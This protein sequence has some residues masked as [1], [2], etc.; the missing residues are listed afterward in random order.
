MHSEGQTFPDDP[1]R[2][3]FKQPSQTNVSLDRFKHLFKYMFNGGS[4][5]KG[6]DD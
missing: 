2:S 3:F 6:G 4:R 1:E 5:K